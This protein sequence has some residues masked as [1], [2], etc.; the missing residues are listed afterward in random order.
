MMP[1]STGTGFSSENVIFDAS[2]T[3]GDGRRQ[4]AACV[5]R[6]QPSGY[7]LYQEHDLDSQWRII[8]ALHRHT[9]VPVPRI[10]AH[11]TEQSA[12]LGQPFFVMERITGEAAGDS[13]PY[14]VKGWLA[15]APPEQRRNV[16]ERGLAV[17]A[18][19]HRADWKTLGLDFLLGS[20]I[21]PVGLASQ[22]D[23][24]EQFLEWVAHGRE[25]PLCAEAVRWLRQHVPDDD[26]LVLN[27]GDARLGNMLFRDFVP[28]AVLDWEMATLSPHSA[29]LGWWIVFNRI[30]TEGIGRANLPGIPH[31][32]EAVAIYE[33]ISGRTVHHLQF[34]QV[35]A[36][37]RAALLLVRYSD[38]LVASGAIS[39]DA[40]RTP[41]RPAMVVLERLLST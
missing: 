29:D 23:H 32:D 3:A 36:A 14:T 39:A 24:D 8:D 5:A 20:T 34:Y 7:S 9:S 41:A 25:L 30:H 35:R 37:L 4:V 38:H 10:I 26:E 18:D 27:W 28:V 33:G 19:I 1:S 12:W 13:P 22:M 21:N 11:D 40:E 16:Y 15:D 17:L 6:I 31:D 2:Y